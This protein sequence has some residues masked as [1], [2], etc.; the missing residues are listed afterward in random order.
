M[1]YERGGRGR[2]RNPGGGRFG[3]RV[4]ESEMKRDATR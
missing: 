4:A 1:N 3:G 2:G